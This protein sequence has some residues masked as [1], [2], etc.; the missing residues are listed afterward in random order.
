MAE[1]YLR[2][3]ITLPKFV[4]QYLLVRFLKKRLKFVFL[5]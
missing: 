3:G 5:F 1:K 2:K 4:F